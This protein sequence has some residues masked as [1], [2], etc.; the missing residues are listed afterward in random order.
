MK[1]RRTKVVCT[2]GPSTIEPADLLSLMRAGMDIARLNMSH[3]E[4]S[5]HKG[6]INTVKKLNTR[7]GF[8]TAIMLDTKGPEIRT[9]DVSEPVKLRRGD[10]L[11]LT[12]RRAVKLPK[13]TVEVNY[14]NFV[15]DVKVGDK[16]LVDNGLLRLTIFK[17]T[18]LD[19]FCQC[20]NGFTL[21]SRRHINLPK[22]N[23]TLPAVTKRDWDDIA[24]GA[25]NGIDFVALS[26]VRRAKDIEDVRAFLQRRKSS[27][28]V[29]AKIESHQSIL[30]LEEIIRA[31]DG[32]LIARGDLGAE[33]PYYEVPV[34]Q[35]E[36]ISRCNEYN[37]PVIVA[38]H[39]LESMIEHPMPTRAEVNDLSQA[40][41]QMADATMLSGE[42][43]AGKYPFESVKTMVSVIERIERE[44]YTNETVLLHET[45]S[46]K[47]EVVE[48]AAVMATN[49]KVKAIVVFT[50]SG[51][52]ALLT[53]RCRPSVPIF[54]FS[55]TPSVE[56]R[57]AMAFGIEA[58][59]YASPD[60]PERKI[61]IAFSILLAKKL[62]KK[63][64]RVI[65][66]SDVLTSDQLKVP[67]VQVRNA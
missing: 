25:K 10:T 39:I 67:S 4:H 34:I 66:I 47:E 49:L 53:S 64:D 5:W 56:K 28:G 44:V 36:I 54:A 19:V 52:M 27:A 31:S 24:F 55:R 48:A 50:H 12:I 61:Q 26:F 6:A 11:I 21:T 57:L 46:V 51:N 62:L 40:V 7:Y 18:K 41:F 9:G 59:H 17:K 38:T 30:H 45:N 29:I 63:G 35:K 65:V 32:V 60:N 23:V 14:D 1:F 33:L 22:S 3:G 37:K 8:R 15:N 13:N 58:F 16:I 42:T 43:A 20:H 2:I